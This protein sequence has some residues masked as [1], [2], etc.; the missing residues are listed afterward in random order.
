MALKFIDSFDHYLALFSGPGSEQPSFKWTSATCT[1]ETGRHGY[2]VTGQLHKAMDFGSN[3]LIMEMSVKTNHVDTLFDIG[4]TNG[5]RQ[6]NLSYT[7]A[8]GAI[9]VWRYGGPRIFQSDPDLVRDGTWYHIGWKVTVHPTN[10][11]VEVRLNGQTIWNVTGI[12]TI[13]DVSGDTFWSGAV[14]RFSLGY[15]GQNGSVFDDL[16]VMDDTDDGINDPRLPGGG[17]FDKFLG[18][19]EIVVKRP[20]GIGTSAEWTPAPA[21][22]NWMNVD[23]IEPDGDTSVNSAA[24]TANGATDFF[25]MEDL[26]VTQD[27]VGAQSLICARKTEEGF[28]A[29]ARVT[30]DG[31]TITVSSPW[32]LP[33]SYSYLV[34]IEPTLPDGTLWTRARWNAIEYGY[35][36]MA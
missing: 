16:I 22:A 34:H 33:D 2:G 21:G 30:K 8:T 7:L 10:G 3:T 12:R 35:R 1:R 32:Y 25:A 15:D 11:A 27:V 13:N 23:D 4:D 19:V 29:I 17:G 31:G 18:A 6:I 24:A 28:A 14:G 36:R 26:T 20:N 9:E 5:D